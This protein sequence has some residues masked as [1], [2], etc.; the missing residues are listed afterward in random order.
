MKIFNFIHIILSELSYQRMLKPK[1]VFQVPSALCDFLLKSNCFRLYI[2]F[3]L[4]EK[5]KVLIT[6]KTFLE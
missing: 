6:F 2:T 3:M 4:K 5:I 1:Y